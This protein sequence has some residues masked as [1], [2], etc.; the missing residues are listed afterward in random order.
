[1]MKKFS[2]IFLFGFSLL[3]FSCG[4]KLDLSQFPIT[5]DPGGINLSDTTYV[6][7]SP[8]WDQFNQPEAILL[9]NEPLIYVAD[10][11]N[12]RVVQLDLAGVEIGSAQFLR[13]RAL[14]Q[15]GN[16]DLLVVADSVLDITFDTVSVVYRIKLVQ[17]GGILSNAVKIPLI[18]SDYPT[19]LSSRKRKFSGIAVYPDN[20]ILL[21]R[22]GPDNTSALDPDNAIINVKGINSITSVTVYG[23]FQTTGN[24]IY[25]I[26]KTSDVTTFRNNPTDFIITRNTIDFGF[27]V[28]WFQY[29]A[30]N[31]AYVPRFL[32]ESNVDLV[33]IQLGTPEAVTVDNN[34]NIYVVDS[35]R[36]S[37]YKFNAN[38][39]LMPESFGG[40]GSGVNQL[41]SPGGVS[42]F[43]KVLYIADTGNNRI[44]RYKLSTDLN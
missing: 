29:D 44:V 43:N 35:Q 33:R 34:R 31:G 22:R 25:S 19:P 40:N 18:V 17:A 9:G 5:N 1:M 4:E 10:T 13:P 30:I 42:F 41:N 23:G 11:R 39:K 12:D 2:I 7:Q 14:A 38:G 37:L 8:T 16:F 3:I 32:P 27:K 36:D 20:S 24:G 21:T 26:E 28:E 15:D 6:Q